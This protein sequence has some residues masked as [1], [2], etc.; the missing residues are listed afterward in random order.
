[1]A[2]SGLAAAFPELGAEPDTPS[3]LAAPV[4]VAEGWGEGGWNGDGVGECGT[5]AAWHRPYFNYFA[6]RCRVVAIKF[7]WEGKEKEEKTGK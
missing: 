5:T 7:L 4:Y 6:S 2:I 1:M 3:R